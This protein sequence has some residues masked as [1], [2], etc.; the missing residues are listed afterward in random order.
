[1][2]DCCWDDNMVESCPALKYASTRNHLYSLGHK[3]EMLAAFSPKLQYI[4][5]WWKQLYGESEGK[6]GK[7]ILPHS[8]CYTTDL[9]SMGQYLQEG[10]RIMFETIICVQQSQKSISIPFDSENADGLNY[11]N[12]KSLSEVNHCAEKGTTLAHHE[13]GVPVIRIEIP[14]ID[15]D[16]LGQLI[17][18]FEFACGISGYMLGVNP[19][20][21]PGVEAYKRNMFALLGKPGLSR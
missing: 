16:H 7:G 18:F 3:V 14:K 6:R 4:N 13:G 15:E 10:E 8:L 1:M 21:Q 11:L 2:Q 5:E 20:N 19:F 12:G 9:H 17:Y